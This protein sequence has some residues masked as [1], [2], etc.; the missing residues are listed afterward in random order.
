MIFF[1][2]NKF[3]DRRKTME[4]I[5]Y[6]FFYKLYHFSLS[7]NTNNYFQKTFITVYNTVGKFSVC[8]VI[9][10]ILK[11]MLVLIK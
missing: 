3:F 4:K 8:F 11:F 10:N 1:E 5:F 7:L 6:F 9:F 2:T